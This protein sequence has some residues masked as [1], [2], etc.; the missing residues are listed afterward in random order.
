MIA[1]AGLVALL[2]GLVGPPAGAQVPSA[3]TAPINQDPLGKLIDVTE[4]WQDYQPAGRFCIKVDSFEITGNTGAT[5]KGSHPAC[6]ASGFAPKAKKLT[7]IK[8]DAPPLCAG[9]RRLFI[10]FSKIPKRNEAPYY[11]AHGH[12]YFRFD[13][14]NWT[15]TADPIAHSPNMKNFTND[16]LFA[17]S[18][19][20]QERI[21]HGFDLHAMSYVS[22]TAH[23]AHAVVQGPYYI[24]PWYVNRAGERIHGVY[25]DVDVTSATR[26]PRPE[27]NEIYYRAGFN[28]GEPTCLDNNFDDYRDGNYF[29]G[30]CVDRFGFSSKGVNP[31]E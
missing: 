30:G 8:I 26:Y 14:F 18:G 11:Y 29:Y 3:P 15:Y 25:L 12:A 20:N 23:F 21:A 22:D 4:Q 2:I 6:R 28:S 10:D 24:G 19:S 27:M 5:E 17:P 31:Y 7:L 13:S 1:R 16:K 9:C